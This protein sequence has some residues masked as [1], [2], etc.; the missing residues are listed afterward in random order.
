MKPS[1]GKYAEW[2]RT[3]GRIQKGMT[4]TEAEQILS[5]PSRLVSAGTNEIIAYR[6]EQIGNAVYGIR[7]VYTDNRVSQC[8]MGFEIV[9]G[10]ARGKGQ[11]RAERFQLFLLVL[12]VAVVFLL[13]Y[14]V[15]TR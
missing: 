5:A 10:D 13:Y 15:K 1:P 7:V 3:I 4:R 14:W 8:Y 12:G 11:K 6:T 2:E 9:E